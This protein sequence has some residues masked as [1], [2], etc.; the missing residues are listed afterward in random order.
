[1]VISSVHKS[2]DNVYL[3]TEYKEAFD[4]FDENGDGKISRD[5]LR[6]MMSNLGQ[7][8]SDKEINDIMTTSDKDGKY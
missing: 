3:N 5:E 6:K 8:P 7:A 2:S 4:M 1:M